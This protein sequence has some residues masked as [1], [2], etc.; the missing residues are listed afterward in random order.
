MKADE[1]TYVLPSCQGPPDFGGTWYRW[2][3]AVCT[4]FLKLNSS[5]SLCRVVQKAPVYH[6]HTDA[7]CREVVWLQAQGY[8]PQLKT[9][10][11]LSRLWRQDGSLKDPSEKASGAAEQVIVA[12]PTAR[13]Y[14][15]PCT[16]RHIY[17]LISITKKLAQFNYHRGNFCLSSHC[18]LS[19]ILGHRQGKTQ[20]V[21]AGRTVISLPWLQFNDRIS[22]INLGSHYG[23]GTERRKEGDDLLRADSSYDCH[24]SNPCLSFPIQGCSG[25]LFPCLSFCS[26][27]ISLY[28]TSPYTHCAH[29]SPTF[30]YFLITSCFHCQH[31]DSSLLCSDLCSATCRSLLTQTSISSVNPHLL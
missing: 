11:F 2:K 7:D 26:C 10:C 16:A 17:V 27:S 29:F 30:Q 1:H 6:S 8:A 23:H 20:A 18:R 15:V 22:L 21:C 14:G 25:L 24:K 31:S 13:N 9:Y 5:Y 4:K 12:S 3:I 19:D 28:L